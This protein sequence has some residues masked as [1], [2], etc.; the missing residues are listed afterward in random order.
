MSEEERERFVTEKIQAQVEESVK[1]VDRMAEDE[2]WKCKN[3]GSTA[4]DAIKS[5]HFEWLGVQTK[6]TKLR[7]IFEEILLEKV[8]LFDN[9]LTRITEY[10]PE[11]STSVWNTPPPVSTPA[12][13]FKSLDRSRSKTMTLNTTTLHKSKST[14][15]STMLTRAHSAAIKKAKG[16]QNDIEGEF[17][18]VK[19]RDKSEF[20]LSGW[21]AKEE[22]EF[23]EQKATFKSNL[24]I[25]QV[26]VLFQFVKKYTKTVK[27]RD[28]MYRKFEHREKT[29]ITPEEL[30]YLCATSLFLNHTL[31]TS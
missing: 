24:R 22:K 19:I 4:K 29:G 28:N 20:L 16:I 5:K 31:A 9:E 6:Y 30:R 7:P 23:L 11:A 1:I 17:C 3:N 25:N 10:V 12:Q 8:K 18:N 27:A 15:S 26:P 21:G 13:K 2:L 14:T